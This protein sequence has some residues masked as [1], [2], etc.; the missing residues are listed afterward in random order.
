MKR[1]DVYFLLAAACFM[2]GG[3]ALGMWMG[4]NER[5][6]LAH[7]HAHINLLGWASLALFGLVY[8]AYPELA[9]KRLAKAHFVLA[10]SGVAIFLPGLPLAMFGRNPIL[11]IVGSNLWLLG[12]ICFLIVLVTGLLRAPSPR[13]AALAPAE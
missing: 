1:I 2:I 5:F 8:R 12:A 7:L 9:T 10:V 6:E 4:I 3:V 11:A 13:P